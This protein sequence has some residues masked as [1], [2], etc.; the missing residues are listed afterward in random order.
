MLV[1]VCESNLTVAPHGTN[2]GEKLYASEPRERDAQEVFL[3]LRGIVLN[4]RQ[5][6][7]EVKQSLKRHK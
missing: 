4:T 2:Y 3:H 7:F 1:Y 6:K 5:H